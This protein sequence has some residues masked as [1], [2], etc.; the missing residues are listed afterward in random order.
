MASKTPI[1]FRLDPE[2][3]SRLGRIRDFHQL[4]TEAATIRKLIRD[5]DRQIS[6]PGKS[7]R[8]SKE[9]D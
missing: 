6:G 7:A 3:R 2:D 8:K 1:Q 5:A 4:D 9:R